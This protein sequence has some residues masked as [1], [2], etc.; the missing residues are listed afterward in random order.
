MMGKSHLQNNPTRKDRSN[1]PLERLHMDILSSSVTLLEGYNYALVI[2]D[3]C[4]GYRWLFGLKTKEDLLKAVQKWYSDI[5]QLR[6]LHNVCVVI[7][8]GEN[9]SHEV[10][11][12]FESKSIKSYFSM[13]S[14]RM[15]RGNRRSIL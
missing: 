11:E 13:N 1:S 14:G 3:D 4:S 6:E 8:A 12:F 2:T 10:I 9:K 15:A 5:A 7:H